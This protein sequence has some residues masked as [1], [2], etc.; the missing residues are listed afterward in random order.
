MAFSTLRVG[1]GTGM[2]RL[3]ELRE[4]AAGCH[5]CPLWKNATQTVFGEGPV[6]AAV[7]LVGEQPGAHE[8]SKGHPFVEPAGR[9]LD[10]A[11]AA[12]GARVRCLRGPGLLLDERGRL[13]G[14]EEP[15]LVRPWVVE[16][17]DERL[18]NALDLAGGAE[19][20]DHVRR[21]RQE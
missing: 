15:R 2:N 18:A 9:I 8:D 12:A 6:G 16:S 14:L 20:L 11:L 4:A 17:V 5:N 7:M 19:H 13:I 10:A 21:R 3:D 1:T